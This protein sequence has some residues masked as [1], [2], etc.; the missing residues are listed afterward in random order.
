MIIYI[1]ADKKK[2]VELRKTEAY[3]KFASVLVSNQKICEICGSNNNL[4]V[5]H[6]LPVSIYPEKL[7]EESNCM[8]LCSGANKFS[9]CHKQYGHLGNFNIY[10]PTVKGLKKY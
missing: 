4:Q 5:H 7:L 8:I 9:G 10:N 2:K 6:I 1:D 3:K